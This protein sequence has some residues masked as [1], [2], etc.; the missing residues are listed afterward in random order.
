MEDLAYQFKNA[1]VPIKK[2][3]N[4]VKLIPSKKIYTFYTKCYCLFEVWNNGRKYPVK[5]DAV[6]SWNNFRKGKIPI[7]HTKYY[8]YER[9]M[10][11]REKY[12]FKYRRYIYDYISRSKME[13]KW[14]F[15]YEIETVSVP[16]FRWVNDLEN[17]KENSIFSEDKPNFI[18]LGKGH[19]CIKSD[20]DAVYHYYKSKKSTI[21][22]STYRSKFYKR[23]LEYKGWFYDLSKDFNII[24]DWNTV[25][26]AYLNHLNLK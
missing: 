16:Y 3:K 23:Q 19:Y 2:F 20:T 5:Y 12:W 18:N 6:F 9:A 7:F 15:R 14:G 22:K 4:Y 11:L 8:K 21:N 25:Y 17:L 24:K 13:E 1:I 10:L 26:E